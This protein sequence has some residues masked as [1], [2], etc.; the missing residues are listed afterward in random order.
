MARHGNKAV[1]R[2]TATE[3]DKRDQEVVRAN[4]ELVAYFKG[5]RTE[6]EARAALK[7]IKAFVRDRERQDP[8]KLRPLPG[9][10]G[11]GAAKR[12]I[13]RQIQ[14]IRKRAARQVRRPRLVVPQEG[15]QTAD[16]QSVSNDKSP[17]K[18]ST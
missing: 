3:P 1:S 8:E 7:I 2:K 9:A 16:S 5:R 10:T 15:R 11:G 18:E 6:R 12:T 13:T 17:S 14:P 4:R